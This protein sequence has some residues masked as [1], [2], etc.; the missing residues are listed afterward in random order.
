VSSEKEEEKRIEDKIGGVN[1]PSQLERTTLLVMV[2]RVKGEG[3][4]PPLPTRLG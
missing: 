2:D 1:L 4:A 3:R